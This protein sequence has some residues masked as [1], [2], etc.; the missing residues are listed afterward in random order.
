M[1]TEIIDSTGDGAG[2]TLN[3]PFGVAVDGSGNVYVAGFSSSNAFK[4]TPGGVITEIIDASG[5]GAGNTRG[6][7]VDIAADGFG[8]VY[9]TGAVSNN[10][11]KITSGGVITEIIDST[12]DGAGNTLIAAGGIAVDPSGNLYVAGTDSDNAFRIS[13]QV[14]VDASATG[15]N[16]GT[17]WTDAYTSLQ[18][19]IADFGVSNI[20]VAEGTYRPD[21]RSCTSDPDCDGPGGG[22]CKLNQCG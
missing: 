15:L 1:I 19:G 5:D 20:W 11:F 14:F 18:D 7:A 10:A 4:I 12:G 2:N 21:V 6:I 17:S 16:N 3:Q 8:N 9:L 22:V 13:P